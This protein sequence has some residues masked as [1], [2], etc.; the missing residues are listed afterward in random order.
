M[1]DEYCTPECHPFFGYRRRFLTTEERQELRKHYRE[2]AVKWIEN[3]K[4][5][6]ETELQAVNERLDEIK[7]QTE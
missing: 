2:N 1:E 3:Y 6:L 7:K 5:S 4:K